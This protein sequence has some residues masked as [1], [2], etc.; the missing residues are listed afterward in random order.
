MADRTLLEELARLYGAE[1]SFHDGL[2][3]H[4]VCS[5]DSLVG[6]LRSLGAPLE[7]PH[8]A[9]DALRVGRLGEWQTVLSPVTVAWGDDAPELALRLPCERC[10]GSVRVSVALDTGD[11]VEREAR[12]EALPIAASVDVEGIGF[13]ELRFGLDRALPIGRHRVGVELG[14]EEWEGFLFCAPRR[15]H[16]DP[17]TRCWGLFVPPYA[18]WSERSAGG[19]DLTD[20]A[21]LVDLVGELGGGMVGTLPLCAAF[22]GEVPH[23][24][25]PYAPVSRLFWNELYLDPAR[26]PELASCAR[27]RKL[28][29]SDAF[30]REAADLRAEPMVDHRRQM[31]LRRRVLEELAACFF[32]ASDGTGLA[33]FVAA[34]PRVM[35]YARFRATVETRGDVWYVWPERMR[36]G[37]LE[38]ADWDERAFRYH[39]WVQWRMTEQL[40]ALCSAARAHGP[41]IYLDMP[42]GVHPDGYD[43]WRERDAFL[44]GCAAGAPPD[45]L[46]T[47]G[48]NWGFAPLSP[49]GMR[50]DGYRYLA[51]CLRVQMELAGVLRIDHVM[52]L[53]RIYCVPPGASAQDGVYVRYRA[54]ELY[55]VLCLES[56]RHQTMI[57]GEDLGTVPPEVREAMDRHG[58][59]RMYVF[60][61]ELRPGQHP[62]IG[63]PAEDS[64]ASLNTHDMPTFEA[65]FSGR[66]VDDRVALGLVD[67]GAA[68]HE[69][70]ERFEVVEALARELGVECEPW[71]VLRAALERLAR[72]RERLL[73]VSL[74]DLWLEPDPQ[75]VPG[76]CEER[77]NWKR[78]AR[79]SLEEL[80]GMP[81]I[82]ELLG[83]LTRRR[84]G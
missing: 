83:E 54:E 78:R 5:D 32:D 20:L 60:P 48:Q 36:E 81:E 70:R 3:R 75:N 28:L 7:R 62:M 44:S 47:A 9:H 21:S 79:H 69:R 84:R 39:L 74:E 73:L 31:A 34:D 24:P 72:G 40:G 41:G 10:E 65:W 43:A 52:G 80:R 66:D 33:D 15:V 27:A 49:S 77:P 6:V 12:L 55:A 71:P 26:V 2:G 4:R 35:D 25:S 67:E 30:A 37:L 19:G 58:L 18:L 51:D 14:S 11:V 59:H 16:L 53:H 13:R 64:V 8:D 46:F 57:V 68:Q 38:P 63:E 17:A 56:A 22:L 50:A 42:L 61:F 45:M 29:A 82:M 76:T 1:T 23:D